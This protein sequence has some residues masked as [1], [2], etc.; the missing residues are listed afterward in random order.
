M[1][2]P[3]KIL[4]SFAIANDETTG[5]TKIGKDCKV[6]RIDAVLSPKRRFLLLALYCRPSQKAKQQ[7]KS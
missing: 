7:H 1:K 3:S 6:Q 4:L 2:I 5:E